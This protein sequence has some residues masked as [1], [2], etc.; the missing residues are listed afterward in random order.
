[1]FPW[2][3]L[4][5]YNLLMKNREAYDWLVHLMS[6]S[7]WHCQLNK[8]LMGFLHQTL[9]HSARNVYARPQYYKQYL[10]VKYWD[11]LVVCLKAI[12]IHNI[13]ISLSEAVLMHRPLS[14]FRKKLTLV[15]FRL[16]IFISLEICQANCRIKNYLQKP[17]EKNSQQSGFL[18]STFLEIYSNH[19]QPY[20]CIKQE[21]WYI[22]P[23]K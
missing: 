18:L 3:D 4:N 17:Q 13:V 2:F 6:E 9:M 20:A 10:T 14:K 12:L 5:Q 21:I 22:W 7:L 23:R 19:P 8:L 1:M 15:A 16:K 11:K